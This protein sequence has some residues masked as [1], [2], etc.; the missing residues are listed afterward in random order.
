MLQQSYVKLKPCTGSVTKFGGAGEK[1]KWD[2]AKTFPSE[3][4]VTRRK[5]KRKKKSEEENDEEEEV[6]NLS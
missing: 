3:P 1:C 6:C 5:K 2:L 4:F